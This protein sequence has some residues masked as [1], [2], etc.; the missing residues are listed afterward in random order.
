MERMKVEK[1]L[2][3]FAFISEMR[4]KRGLMVQTEVRFSEGI[5]HL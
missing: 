2:D 5:A 4:Q 1:S 3:I